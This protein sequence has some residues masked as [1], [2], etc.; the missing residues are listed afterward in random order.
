[1]CLSNIL[2]P[3]QH[4]GNVYF[5]VIHDFSIIMHVNTTFISQFL[6]AY[7][8]VYLRDQLRY[9]SS[10]CI[11]RSPIPVLSDGISFMQLRREQTKC[12]KKNCTPTKQG[13]I[14][15]PVH[16]GFSRHSNL[17]KQPVIIYLLRLLQLSYR[18]RSDAPLENGC[19]LLD[20]QSQIWPSRLFSGK[21][22]LR[23]E[24]TLTFW[25]SI[26]QKIILQARRISK[27]TAIIDD[28][29]IKRT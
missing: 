21:Q 22:D 20:S 4:K 26:W 2:E 11:F 3:I 1:M 9:I 8:C 15:S 27:L 23:V 13:T 10:F 6:S 19:E 14:K 12:T 24:L 28:T 18:E 25:G 7:K 29:E 16:N 17:V 5:V